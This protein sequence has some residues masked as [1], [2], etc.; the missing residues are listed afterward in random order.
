M[1]HEIQRLLDN[2]EAVLKPIR[3][4]AEHVFKKKGADQS[5]FED[6]SSRENGSES[7]S[8]T[9]ERTTQSDSR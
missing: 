8:E 7:N 2:G 3:K 1:M 9:V 5:S 6:R 4:K